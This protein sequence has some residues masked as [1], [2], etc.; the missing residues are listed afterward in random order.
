MSSGLLEESKK[1][2]SKFQQTRSIL[3]GNKYDNVNWLRKGIYNTYSLWRLTKAETGNAL[4]ASARAIREISKNTKNG[5]KDW[6]K[7][8]GFGEAVKDAGKKMTTVGKSI[9]DFTVRHAKNAGGL[10]AAGAQKAYEKGKEFGNWISDSEFGK[11]VASYGKKTGKAVGGWFRSAGAWIKDKAIR[12]S[13]S[14]MA[15]KIK[16]GFKSAGHKISTAAKGAAEIAVNAADKVATPIVNTAK[17]LHNSAFG[18]NVRSAG[19]WI[20]KKTV[21]GMS[22]LAHHAA[23]GYDYVKSH[24]IDWKFNKDRTYGFEDNQIKEMLRVKESSGVYEEKMNRFRQDVLSKKEIRDHLNIRLDKERIKRNAGDMEKGKTGDVELVEINKEGKFVKDT[25]GAGMLQSLNKYDLANVMIPDTEGKKRVK[26]TLDELQKKAKKEE[27][28]KK[29]SVDRE[30]KVAQ[31]NMKTAFVEGEAYLG[32]FDKTL[33]VTNFAKAFGNAINMAEGKEKEKNMASLVTNLMD[34][35]GKIL[36]MMDKAGSYA[37]LAGALNFAVTGINMPK[38]D[39]DKLQQLQT[40]IGDVQ[41]GMKILGAVLKQGG[42]KNSLADQSFYLGPLLTIMDGV[43]SFNKLAETNEKLKALKEEDRSLNL[44]DQNVIRHIDQSNAD[45]IRQNNDKKV[46]TVLNTSVNTVLS[47]VGLATNTGLITYGISTALSHVSP[48]D[49]VVNVMKGKTDHDLMVEDVFGSKDAYNKYKEQYSLRGSDIDRE[50]LRETGIGSVKE[51][52]SRV[53]AETALHLH[54]RIR[55]A[56]QFGIEN[57]A[58]KLKDAGGLQGKSAKEIYK[59]IGGREDFD[60]IVGRDKI[61][62]HENKVEEYKKR[63]AEE[64]KKQIEEKNAQLL[65]GRNK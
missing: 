43:D 16:A 28:Q 26:L 38:A 64:Y 18:K 53:R 59:E 9:K 13:E 56:E 58:T 54:S 41:S 49:L 47:T 12:F 27:M 45:L 37:N 35:A 39:A 63:K 60:K 23:S 25:P 31:K 17:K 22:A 1:Q 42:L 33:P 4:S 21:K 5:V 29:Y 24:I 14:S 62:V 6:Y 11:A 7:E 44:T 61:K 51:Y 50:I 48:V 36:K 10:M 55:Q 34:E 3:Y 40:A 15:N 20:G 46:Q 32:A 65:K 8:S 57:G 52:A 30:L 2:Q 19:A